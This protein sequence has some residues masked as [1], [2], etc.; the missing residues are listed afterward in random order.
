[1][2]GRHETLIATNSC[3][4]RCHVENLMERIARYFMFVSIHF[5]VC[6]AIG[7]LFSVHLI[8]L[9]FYKSQIDLGVF[10][11]FSYVSLR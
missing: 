11:K 8:L 10:D 7:A 5:R 3:L 1:M 2:S 4:Q 6:F 9:S